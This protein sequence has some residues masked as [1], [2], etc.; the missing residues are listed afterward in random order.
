MADPKEGGQESEAQVRNDT[1]ESSNGKKELPD[2]TVSSS[3]SFPSREFSLRPAVPSGSSIRNSFSLRSSLLSSSLSPGK[4]GSLTS[5]K[6][7]VLNPPRLSNPFEKSDVTESTSKNSKENEPEEKEPTSSSQEEE[8]KPS[9]S[10]S[11]GPKSSVSFLPLGVDK[12]ASQSQAQPPGPPVPSSPNLGFVFGQNIREKIVCTSTT[13]TTTAEAS[14]SSDASSSHGSSEEVTTNGTSSEMLFSDSVKKEV[15]DK[16]TDGGGKTLSEAAREYEEARAVKRKYEAVTVFTGEEEESNVL[17]INC[18]L[19]AWGNGTWVEKGRCTLR[20]NDL[21][22]SPPQYRLIVRA[23]GNFR[24]LLNTMLWSAMTVDRASF[25]SMRITAMDDNRV[26]KVFLVMASPKEMDQLEK[27]LDWRVNN[28][29]KLAGEEITPK[30]PKSEV[31][32][33]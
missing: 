11:T 13:T 14:N 21:P 16:T 6:P 32:A 30:K 17:Q 1:V 29:K 31:E 4:S 19:F 18:K 26:V 9:I 8:S 3:T 20:V 28:L 2:Q 25:K 23:T 27:C 15:P 33:S 7:F 12:G 22:T 5:S 10:S 24:V